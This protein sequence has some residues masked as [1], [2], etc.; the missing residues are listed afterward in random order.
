MCS[1]DTQGGYEFYAV[2]IEDCSNSNSIIKVLPNAQVKIN[3]KCE[4]VAN[5]CHNITAVKKILS[6]KTTIH[7]RSM[8]IYDTNNTLDCKRLDIISKQEIVRLITAFSGLTSC[9][10]FKIG[11]HCNNSTVKLTSAAKTI[12]MLSIASKDGDILRIIDDV[13]LEG[14]N[15]CVDVKI[16]MIK[17]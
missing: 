5:I 12:K 16:K 17:Y 3:K 11:I 8:K 15:A 13:S 7:Q 2:E 9:K 1:Y 6:A 14:A 10:N 4:F